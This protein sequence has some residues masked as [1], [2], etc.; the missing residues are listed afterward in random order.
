MA[1]DSK[2][3][4]PSSPDCEG[5]PTSNLMCL[6]PRSS[7]L[8]QRFEETALQ[9]TDSETPAPVCF[10]DFQKWQ[11]WLYRGE[12][13]GGNWRHEVPS[14]AKRMLKAESYLNISGH[15]FMF[16]NSFLINVN[17]FRTD[18]RWA[19][20]LPWSPGLRTNSMWL[21]FWMP[22]F[23]SLVN[24]SVHVTVKACPERAS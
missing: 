6:L 7:A 20:C 22:T 5:T 15:F 8:D 14:E 11:G 18:L 2:C 21:Q 12:S 10:P 16:I 13:L 23:I 9:W 17:F 3:W 24:I 4:C 19:P 1:N